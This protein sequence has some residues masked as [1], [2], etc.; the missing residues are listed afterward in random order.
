MASFSREAIFLR[1]VGADSLEVEV[2]ASQVR[3]WAVDA[4]IQGTLLQNGEHT[5]VQTYKQSG[6]CQVVL[7]EKLLNR[8]AGN[9]LEN[10]VENGSSRRTDLMH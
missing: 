9:H 1:Q 5:Y 10:M 2:V 6:P 8:P 7:G 3:S 4:S